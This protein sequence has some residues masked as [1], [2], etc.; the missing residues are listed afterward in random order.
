[1][2]TWYVNLK[3]QNFK[4]MWNVCVSRRAFSSLRSLDKRLL[5]SGFRLG[6]SRNE[7]GASG[8]F[9]K[10]FPALDVALIRSASVAA[11]HSQR[12]ASTSKFCLLSG[13]LA[14]R[15]ARLG[16]TPIE[17]PLQWM[18]DFEPDSCV[19]GVPTS[20]PELLLGGQLRCASCSPRSEAPPS[21]ILAQSISTG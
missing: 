11:Y 15:Q 1:M 20:T 18:Q 9:R 10:R 6:M 21:L 5:A 16:G 12:M 14:C 3:R 2:D 7:Q 17:T 19:L 4:P 13:S 8:R